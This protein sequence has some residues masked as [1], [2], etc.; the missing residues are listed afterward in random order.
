MILKRAKTLGFFSQIYR[1]KYLFYS[2]WKQFQVFNSEIWI[3]GNSQ[4]RCSQDW[5]GGCGTPKM[6]TF[7]TQKWTFWTSPLNPLTRNLILAHF[8]AKSGPFGR[9]VGAAH[10]S[11]TRYFSVPLF[12]LRF[13]YFTLKIYQNLL[14]FQMRM[15]GES[16]PRP[17]IISHTTEPLDQRGMSCQT[18]DFNPW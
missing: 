16:T 18:S 15:W 1:F 2:N 5:N 8:V 6:L 14:F 13:L 4:A 17:I 10:P 3:Q 7:W 9:L 11:R 12:G